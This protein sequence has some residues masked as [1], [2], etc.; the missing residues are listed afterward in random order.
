MKTMIDIIEQKQA[1]LELSDQ[2]IRKVIEDYDKGIIPDYQMSALLMA[3]YFQGMSQ[4]ETSVLLQSMVDSGVRLEWQ[5]LDGPVV[6]KH[7]TGGVGDKISLMLAPL[8]AVYGCY[9]P[10][11]SGRGLGHTG[12]TLDKLDSI[13]G[14]RTQLSLD[15]IQ[16]LLPKVGCV[17][18]GQT[19]EIAPVDKKMYA[20]RDVTGTIR[21]IPLI[22]ASILSKKLSEGLDALVIDLKV[23]RGAFAKDLDFAF[24]LAR[25]LFYNANQA[26]IATR[27]LLTKMDI[28]IGQTIG[29]WLEVK[30][31]MEWLQGKEGNPELTELTLE[32]G[33][34]V[35]IA[36]N[37]GTKDEIKQR[38]IDLWKS[39]KA[40]E[41]WLQ[42]VEAQGG[43]CS[44]LVNLEKMPKAK[45]VSP[46]LSNQEGYLNG[47]NAYHLGK[48]A[49]LLGAGR[50]VVTDQ[51]NP[52]AGFQFL[53]KWGEYVSKG[54][55]ILEIH[56]H[57]ESIVPYV[58]EQCLLSLEIE[59]TQKNQ[60][61]W[62]IQEY[63]ENGKSK[64]ERI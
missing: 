54:E 18:A 30:E 41:K 5:N 13:P 37:L 4:Q 51:V 9:V 11:I 1:G 14:F 34:A 20:L 39:G 15:E 57:D 23:G 46:I 38:L 26:K 63:P 43:D 31:A 35:L 19:D 16:H 48:L 10:M 47:A 50:K 3:I 64:R 33:T 49:V 36:A 28:P 52:L 61:S 7:S 44:Y 12:G 27:V 29:N 59:E 17:M 42:I 45:V 53:K 40:F 6:D 22:T 62:I 58:S 8:L 21:A 56:T 55:P 24:K 25:S 32:L 60:T 2:D